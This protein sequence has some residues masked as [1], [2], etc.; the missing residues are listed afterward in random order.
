MSNST[1]E[2]Q[3]SDNSEMI[4][5]ESI[6][7]NTR[8][9]ARH[10]LIEI[11]EKAK[12]F[13]SAQRNFI[14]IAKNI[15][16]TAE[17]AIPNAKW[18]GSTKANETY[19]HFLIQIEKILTIAK[20]IFTDET[21]RNI[22]ANAERNLAIAK[23]MFKNENVEVCDDI[24]DI[25]IY[26]NMIKNVEQVSLINERNYVDIILNAQNLLASVEHNLGMI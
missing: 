7:R 5:Q 6:I 16:E 19:E 3:T 12:S 22:F 18:Y 1:N 9:S 13:M 14:D 24:F 20:Q 23:R 15:L 25:N 21:C 8:M 11:I 26:K 10:R 4:T 17:Y 2:A